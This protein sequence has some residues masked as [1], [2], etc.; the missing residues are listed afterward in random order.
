V[1]DNKQQLTEVDARQVV[2]QGNLL[3]TE[4]LLDGDRIV[5]ASLDGRVICNNHT[6]NTEKQK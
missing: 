5:R 4:M 6:F 3:G 2:L 1:Q